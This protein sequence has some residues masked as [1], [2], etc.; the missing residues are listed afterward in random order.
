LIQYFLNQ[1]EFEAGLIDL[2]RWND[3]AN[4]L[5]LIVARGFGVMDDQRIVLNVDP[6]GEY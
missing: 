2:L 1:F 3:S 4:I 6:G 5:V